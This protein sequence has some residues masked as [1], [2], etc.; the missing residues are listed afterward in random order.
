MPRPAR[1]AT[2]AHGK[3]KPDVGRRIRPPGVVSDEMCRSEPIQRE[4][5]QPIVKNPLRTACRRCARRPMSDGSPD[6]VHRWLRGA[7]GYEPVHRRQQFHTE[8]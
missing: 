5:D 4:A 2:T 7:T 8:W 3:E 1:G 6:A